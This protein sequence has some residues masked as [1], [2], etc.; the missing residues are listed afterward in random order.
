MFSN[1][2]LRSGNLIQREAGTEMFLAVK[3]KT[4]Q[5][6]VTCQHGHGT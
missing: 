1:R 4:M 3:P 5:S 6:F 2:I